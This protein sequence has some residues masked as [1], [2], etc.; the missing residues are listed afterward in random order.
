MRIV[1]IGSFI[2]LACAPLPAIAS[3]ADLP[4]VGCIVTHTDRLPNADLVDLVGAHFQPTSKGGKVAMTVVSKVVQNCRRTYGWGKPRENAA[5]QF[6]SMRVL[7][8]DAIE[9][10]RR[11]GLTDGIVTRYVEGLT[12]EGRAIYAKGGVTPELNRAAFAYLQN[13]GVK[14]E[15]LTPADVQALGQA[16][17][18]AIYSEI[19]EHDAEKAYAG[20]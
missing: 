12:P 1:F 3:N 16:F 14:I 7:R 9:R 17:N 11:F 10:G 8:E 15:G 19:G 4:P 2:A 13:V 6:F 18:M 5:V 20:K